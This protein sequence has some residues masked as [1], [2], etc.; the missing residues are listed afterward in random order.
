MTGLAMNMRCVGNWLFDRT[1]IV[2]AARRAQG[3]STT[4]ATRER[5]S[6]GWRAFA[7]HD[8]GGGPSP[9]MTDGA[10]SGWG[11]SNGR[12]TSP[13]GWYKVRLGA[14]S[15]S[16]GF[17]GGCHDG[18]RGSPRRHRRGPAPTPPMQPYDPFCAARHRASSAGAVAWSRRRP[19]EPVQRAGFARRGRRTSAWIAFL[20]DWDMIARSR[21]KAAPRRRLR[22]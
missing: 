17:S 21:R 19:A 1:E 11:Q 5:Q 13:G 8:E 4:F 22:Q 18:P 20:R 15:V 14:G 7:G 16:R 10:S 2:A 3:R 12:V 9:A 6:R